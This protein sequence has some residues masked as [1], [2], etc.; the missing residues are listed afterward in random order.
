[1]FANSLEA[2][3]NRICEQRSGEPSD[4]L[5]SLVLHWSGGGRAHRAG[6]RHLGSPAVSGSIAAAALALRRPCG[7]CFGSAEVS[8]IERRIDDALVVAVSRSCPVGLRLPAGMTWEEIHREA[9]RVRSLAFEAGERVDLGDGD[10]ECD[11]GRDVDGE[12]GCREYE[13]DDLPW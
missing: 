12:C 4:A 6:C 13:G 9:G 7:T 2:N 1:M 3:V 10:S 11:C 5:D 8:R